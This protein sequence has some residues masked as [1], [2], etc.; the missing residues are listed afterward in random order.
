MIGLFVTKV[1]SVVKVR[2]N[3]SIDKGRMKG[4]TTRIG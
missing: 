1:R 4:H 3:Q 2:A